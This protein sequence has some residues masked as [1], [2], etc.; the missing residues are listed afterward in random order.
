[1]RSP[2]AIRSAA[3]PFATCFERRCNS[4][5]VQRWIGP[6]TVRETISP[7]G[8]HRAACSP[9]SDLAS[10]LPWAC[11][12][13]SHRSD[14]S[15]AG[16]RHPGRNRLADVELPQPAENAFGFGF[17]EPV[18][19]EVA[20]D[21]LALPFAGV[22]LELRRDVGE[23]DA[24]Q[25]GRRIDALV[26]APAADHV[27]S[28]STLVIPDVPRVDLDHRVIEPAELLREE[29]DGVEERCKHRV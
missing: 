28:E 12:L 15:C 3:S 29:K 2:A 22:A 6:S 23:W 10:F 25:H 21:A 4:P 18:L 17:R 16:G 14:R 13:R 24:H 20:R 1:M 26:V 7:A 9:A 8:W 5:Y 11:R 19:V 27:E